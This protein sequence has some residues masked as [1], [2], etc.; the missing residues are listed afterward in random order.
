MLIVAHLWMM[1][2]WQL[3]HIRQSLRRL[4]YRN[5]TV[6]YWGKRDLGGIKN[7]LQDWFTWVT[8]IEGN[9]NEEG[10][11][12]IIIENRRQERDVEMTIPIEEEDSSDILNTYFAIWTCAEW[13]SSTIASGSYSRIPNNILNRIKRFAS[14]KCNTNLSNRGCIFFMIWIHE[15]TCNC[16]TS[17]D[18]QDVTMEAARNGNPSDNSKSST[19]WQFSSPKIS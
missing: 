15:Y 11:E 18:A 1:A 13:E 16:G 2:T 10:A 6:S 7:W 8:T 17:A 5:Q 3:E 14:T 9:R 19:C 4:W 12:E